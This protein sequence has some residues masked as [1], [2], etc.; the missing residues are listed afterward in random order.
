MI[1]APETLSRHDYE[2]VARRLAEDIA[3]GMDPSR[4]IGAG[5]EYVKSRP[6]VPGDS[7][8]TMDW[9]VFARTG[10]PFVKEFEALNRTSVYIIVDTSTS[11]SVTSVKLTKH[12]IAVWIASAFGLIAQTQLRPVFVL[13]GGARDSTLSAGSTGNDLRRAIEP[14]RAPGVREPTNIKRT[15]DE[16]HARA[17]RGSMILVLSDLHDPEALNSL[18]KVAPQH[19]CL[20]IH[21]V[22]PAEE[23][24]QGIGFV[25][26]I[27][28]ERGGVALVASDSMRCDSDGIHREVARAGA[29]Y[30]RLRTDREFVAPLRHFLS[31]RPATGGGRRS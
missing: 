30:L 13:S 18:R 11:M 9:K 27:E 15:I 21:L 25:Q 26:A 24:L 19:D 6:Y 17:I 2:I 10:K 31:S 8:R 16:I 5:Y 28:A 4:F 7:M 23:S 29:S 20:V 22:D 14:L 3:H 12:D 1:P